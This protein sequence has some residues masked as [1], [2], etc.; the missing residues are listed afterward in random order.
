MEVIVK[1][2]PACLW[3]EWFATRIKNICPRA[4]IVRKKSQKNRS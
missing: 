2:G 3:Y 4:K 1:H